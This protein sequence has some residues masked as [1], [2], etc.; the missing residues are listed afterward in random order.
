[1]REAVSALGYAASAWS[2]V[3]GEPTCGLNQTIQAVQ[4]LPPCPAEVDPKVITWC[5]ETAG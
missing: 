5:R 3:S 4:P 2:L 1:L